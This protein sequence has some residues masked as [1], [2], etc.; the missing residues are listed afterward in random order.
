[1]D[2]QRT[3]FAQNREADQHHRSYPHRPYVTV[4]YFGQLS[5][6]RTFTPQNQ[7]LAGIALRQR[8]ALDALHP[9]EPL[10]RIIVANAGARMQL[11]D[12]TVAIS[13]NSGAVSSGQCTARIVPGAGGS[14]NLIMIGQAPDL[15]QQPDANPYL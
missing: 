10:L 1:M 3:I 8:H 11:A 12:Q 9:A 15:P 2:I 4:I 14:A 6:L 13:R 7:Q 5:G